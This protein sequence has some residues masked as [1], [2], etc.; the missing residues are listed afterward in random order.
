LNAN[1]WS[2]SVGDFPPARFDR[3]IAAV[4]EHNQAALITADMPILLL[5]GGATDLMV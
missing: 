4:Y 5:C 3:C 1:V 2:T